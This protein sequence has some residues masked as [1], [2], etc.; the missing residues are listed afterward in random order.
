MTN[1]ALVTT[2]RVRVVESFIQ[3]T[4]PLAETLVVGD[5][6]RFDTSTGKFT[7]SN[8]SAAGEART[9]GILVSKDGAGAVGTAVRKGVLDGFALTALDYDAIVYLSDTDKTLA[10]A[11][12]TVTTAIVGRVIPG[13]AT[14]LGTAADKLLFVDL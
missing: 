1:L 14:T 6:V 3:Q 5:A 7:G 2:G 10:D 11:A 8:A 13:F 12:G 9:Y 4:A